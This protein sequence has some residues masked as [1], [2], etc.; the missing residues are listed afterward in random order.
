M[1]ACMR[2][3]GSSACS[4]APVFSTQVALS[5]AM[6]SAAVRYSYHSIC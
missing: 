6:G 3:R 4:P 5:G 1:S 2:G